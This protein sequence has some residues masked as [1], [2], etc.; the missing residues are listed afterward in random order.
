MN[1][2]SKYHHRHHRGACGKSEPSFS[3]SGPLRQT[4]PRG[5]RMASGPKP[6]YIV[7]GRGRKGHPGCRVCQVPRAGVPATSVQGQEMSDRQRR[8]DR[9]ACD[10]DMWGGRW[11]LAGWAW[12][13]QLGGKSYARSSQA[14]VTW[15]NQAAA[16]GTGRVPERMGV[17]EHVTNIQDGNRPRVCVQRHSVLGLDGN[18]MTLEPTLVERPSTLWSP[19]PPSHRR[20]CDCGLQGRGRVEFSASPHLQGHKQQ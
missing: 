8:A 2:T 3:S 20:T 12:W 13:L 16:W 18:L 10:M 11:P 14:K 19:K 1:T 17:H 4:F 5:K 6:R 15:A 7:D 9:M